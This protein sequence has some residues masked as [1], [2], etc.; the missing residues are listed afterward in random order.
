MKWK[1]LVLI[2]IF[3]PAFVL[4]S[5]GE[6]FNSLLERF[7]SGEDPVSTTEVLSVPEPVLPT[8]EIEEP[9]DV[10]KA[11]VQEENELQFVEDSLRQNEKVLIEIKDE[12]DLVQYQL[13]QLDSDL[14]IERSMQNERNKAV[15]KWR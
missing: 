7:F 4:A 13:E 6:Q 14:S 15:I 12:H 2:T 8:I 5:F 10:R 3:V 11:I 1:Y 9:T